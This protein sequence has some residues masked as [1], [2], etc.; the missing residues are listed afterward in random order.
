MSSQEGQKDYQVFLLM[1]SFTSP[2]WS[3]CAN[4][5]TQLHT[6]SMQSQKW[7]QIVS[8][9]ANDANGPTMAHFR[10]TFRD[11]PQRKSVQ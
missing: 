10:A 4:V 9:H 11:R 2:I 1:K 5:K 8:G 6:K 7:T 3:W